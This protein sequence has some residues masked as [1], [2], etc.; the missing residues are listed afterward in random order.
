VSARAPSARDHLRRTDVV[1]LL[2]LARRLVP[3]PIRPTVLA[4]AFDDRDGY[5]AFE[6]LVATVFPQDYR[7]IMEPVDVAAHEG[8][9]G[10]RMAALIRCVE[11][12]YFP[13][14][15]VWDPD[16]SYRSFMEAI[17]F[18]YHSW[19]E[20]DLHFLDAH[21]DADEVLLVAALAPF[22]R[23][24]IG[25]A[26]FDLAAATCSAATLALL[27]RIPTPADEARWQ[28]H[29]HD[30]PRYGP[31]A[32]MLR[33]LRGATGV[34]QLDFSPE[35]YENDIDWS[36]DN[37]RW[38]RDEHRRARAMLDRIGAFAAWLREHP[39]ERFDQLVHDVYREE[40]A[41]LGQQATADETPAGGDGG[42]P[43]PHPDQLPL[44]L[45]AAP[46]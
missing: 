7:T 6:R 17:P 34:A 15:E 36:L 35:S 32:D 8:L 2:G 5:R 40:I 4:H 11:R 9:A 23:E 21:G 18:A 44:S 20:S 45:G 14:L 12:D 46:G 29:W 19:G 33:W 39:R 25:D 1:S 38:L 24:E 42:S 41:T 26:I 3:G 22:V 16:T 37:L 43:R 10:A 31:L 30:H 13:C 27:A 28:Q